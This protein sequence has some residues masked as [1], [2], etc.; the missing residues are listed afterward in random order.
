MSD[1]SALQ[2]SPALCC[3]LTADCATLL[4]VCRVPDITALI[5]LQTVKLNLVVGAMDQIKKLQG[6]SKSLL[7]GLWWLNMCSPSIALLPGATHCRYA[8]CT[9]PQCAASDSDRPVAL[10]HEW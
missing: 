3:N 8:S 4:C 2:V 10:R 9:M 1:N 6:L 7:D 5:N